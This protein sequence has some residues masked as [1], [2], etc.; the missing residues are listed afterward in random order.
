MQRAAAVLVRH[1]LEAEPLTFGAPLEIVSET[2]RFCFRARRR[3]AHHALAA[4]VLV[5]DVP[6]RPTLED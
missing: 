1:R 4:V 2:A 3:R 5:L 6:A